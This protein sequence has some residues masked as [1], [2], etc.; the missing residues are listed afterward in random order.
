MYY[1]IVIY[2]DSILYTSQ[3][4]CPRLTIFRTIKAILG[5]VY[6]GVNSACMYVNVTTSQAAVL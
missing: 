5:T 6:T 3:G 2:R 1:A 4:G